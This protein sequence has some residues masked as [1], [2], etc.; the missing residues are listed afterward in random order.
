[1]YQ[2][3]ADARCRIQLDLDG[4]VV[5][6]WDASRMEQVLINLLSNALKYGAGAPIHLVVRGLEGRA[7]LV[8]RDHGIGIAETDQARIFERFERAVSVRNFG[9]LGL[10]LYIVRWIVTSHGGTIRVES[11]P[12]AGATFIIELP[13]RPAEAGSSGRPRGPAPTGLA[14]ANSRWMNVMR[15]APLLRELAP[16]AEIENGDKRMKAVRSGG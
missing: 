4:P 14:P 1:M 16:S 8:V 7:L 11:A 15:W 6:D 13:L 10:G 2:Q 3:L 12:G 5:G 9:G